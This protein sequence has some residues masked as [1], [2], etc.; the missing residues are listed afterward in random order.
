MSDK[1]TCIQNILRTQCL[2][3]RK[4]VNRKFGKRSEKVLLQ[5]KYTD[6]HLAHEKVLNITCHREMKTKTWNYN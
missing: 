3:I 5:R 6:G 2:T 4:Q 1:R